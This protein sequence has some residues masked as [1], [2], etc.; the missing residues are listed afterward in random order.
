[1]FE[2]EIQSY[3]ESNSMAWS[4][5]TKCTEKARFNK[6]LGVLDGNAQKLWAYMDGKSAYYKLITFNRVIEFFSHSFPGKENPYLIWKK[7][8]A[9]LFKYVYSRKEIGYS[10]EDVR[11]KINSIENSLIRNKALELLSTGMRYNESLTLDASTN[12]IVGKGNKRRKVFISDELKQLPKYNGS[13]WGFYSE[14][15]KVGIKPHELRKLF[16]TRLAQKGVSQI[17]LLKIMGWESME[18]AK[19]YLQPDNDKQINNFIQE[20]I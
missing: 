19:I 11:K 1:M 9:R 15:N 8:N 16:A 4:E 17:N 3:L 14:L 13:Y 12:S 6:L 5:S 7:K 10:F 20:A 2:K 18:T